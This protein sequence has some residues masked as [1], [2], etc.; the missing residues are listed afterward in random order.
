MFWGINAFKFEGD[1]AKLNHLQ[2]A[3]QSDLES[4]LE[5]WGGSSPSLVLVKADTLDLALEKNDALCDLLKKIQKKG[6]IDKIT[7][8]SD[9]FPSSKKRKE[10]ER[11]FKTLVSEKKI[12][13][14]EQM[15]KAEA[16]LAGFKHG[17]FQS[18]I[19]TLKQG[20]ADFSIKDF[21]D[22]VLKKLIDSKV[23]F[24]EDEVY[25]LTTLQI[26][27][28][29]LIP[30]IIEQIKSTVHGSMFLDKK[31]FITTIT[32]LVAKEFKKLFLFA[33]ASMILVLTVF[34]R[35]L[36]IVSIIVTPVFLA[37]FITAGIL[38]LLNIPINL[39]SMIFIVFVF[40][41]GVDFS[42]FLANHEIHK[43]DDEPNV[44]A[45]AVIVCA[46]TTI[47]AFIC[48]AFA[49]HEALFSIGVAGLTGM[50]TSLILSLML[51]PYLMERFIRPKDKRRLNG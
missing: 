46:M 15:I 21:D 8:L 1:V 44:T 20:H 42:I 41:V 34:F 7:S 11:H 35:N 37:A 25:I 16:R 30:G 4:F 26:K 38:G 27:D 13:Q 39:I 22:T 45:G 40:G 24:Q 48:L 28:K 10:N 33:A 29:I 19:K 5:T 23:V 51:T 36:K 6:S 17:T 14:I 9:I 32:S 3:T 12:I 50:V 47:G 31:Y 49:R 18:F 2:P 43:D